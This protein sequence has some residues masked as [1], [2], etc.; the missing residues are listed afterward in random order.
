MHVALIATSAVALLLAACQP[1]SP[2]ATL[3]V[4]P[5][6]AV[7]AGGA[8]AQSL[9]TEVQRLL[10]AARE[11]G[12]TELNV[13]WG[14]GTLTHEVTAKYEAL[15]NRMYGTSVK[16]NLTPGPSMPD[17]LSKIVQE[18][19]AG[20]KASTAVFLGTETNFAAMV[21]REVL[22]E[23]DFTR[24]SPRIPPELVAT[25]NI[26]LETWSIIP[27]IV[28][29]TEFVPVAQAPKS[30]EDVLDPKW[31]GKIAT[32]PYASPLDRVAIRPEWG[33][34]R[35]KAFV[36]RLAEHAGGVIRSGEDTR[37]ASGEFLIYVMG[38]SHHTR[39]LQRQGGSV[40][41]VIPPDAAV[42]GVL[43]MGVPRNSAQP[44]LGKLFINTVVSEEG[45]R[46]LWDAASADHHALPG[47]RM[48]A[49]VAELK[50][51]GSG[52]FEIRP[53]VL[54][55]RPELKQLT[56]DLDKILTQAR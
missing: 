14:L 11:A 20:H 29:N 39:S 8:S 32:P 37:V 31:K 1:P 38:Y 18:L 10:A 28:H 13:S 9:P 47:S 15:F 40:A 55:E 54:L 6:S 46:I 49:E 43:L 34:D 44:N 56:A 25:G 36:T 42:A 19:A 4:A 53:R 51:K 24:L 22:E 33:P 48:E 23:Y 7:Q 27:A 3:R 17:M 41:Y 5:E 26:G 12:E 30:L 50:A 45:Q 52:I 35:M 2:S 16:V 21:D